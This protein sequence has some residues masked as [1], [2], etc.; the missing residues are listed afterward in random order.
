[1]LFMTVIDAFAPRPNAATSGLPEVLPLVPP[2]DCDP[3]VPPIRLVS[4]LAV[5]PVPPVTPPPKPPF[6]E[7]A[8]HEG[9]VD[10]PAPPPPPATIRTEL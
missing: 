10:P 4:P 7:Y 6:V 8:L 3:P 5:V 9:S 2:A 1:M